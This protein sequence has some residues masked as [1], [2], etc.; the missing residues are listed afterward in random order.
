MRD[1]GNIFIKR[2][3][4]VGL[5]IFELAVI[6]VLIFGVEVLAIAMKFSLKIKLP[7]IIIRAIGGGHTKS[8]S[9]HIGGSEA[10][11]YGRRPR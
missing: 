5:A 6:F 3:V 7:L 1:V 2:S 9:L 10:E 4:A 8:V 11:G